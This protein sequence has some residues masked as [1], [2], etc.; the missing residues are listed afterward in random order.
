[1]PRLCVCGKIVDR[2][3][4]TCNVRSKSPYESGYDHLHRK[5]SERHR[6]NYPLCEFCVREVGAV[7]AKPSEHLH[8][9]IKISENPTIRN[10]QNNWLAVC[11]EC[12]LR[13]EGD[14]I[15]G[16]EVKKWSIE[17]YEKVLYA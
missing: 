4:P 17:N 7:K 3:C 5:S 14:T 8:H 12:H 11:Q 2:K 16:M 13:L 6:K 15:L 1:M 10:D 9:I